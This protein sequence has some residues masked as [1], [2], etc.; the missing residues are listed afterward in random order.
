MSPEHCAGQGLD[1]RSDLYALSVIL[2]RCVTG[3]LP[4][5][6]DDLF[7]VMDRHR[8]MVPPDPRNLVD[9]PLPEALVACLA[10]GLAKHPGQR[11]A[12]AADMR[13]ALQAVTGISERPE[14]SAMATPLAAISRDSRPGT[15][16][17]FLRFADLPTP[18]GQGEAPRTRAAAPV[19]RTTAKYGAVTAD[20][21]AGLHH[22][23]PLLDQPEPE[24]T[25]ELAYAPDSRRGRGHLWPAALAIAAALLMV[26]LALFGGN[27]EPTAPASAEATAGAGP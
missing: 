9:Q 7:V 10:R 12:N 11:F 15:E 27:S 17:R 5:E 3:E 16:T 14:I 20:A 24:F 26:G 18:A 21:L 4:F 6:D 19:M 1:G 13:T 23:A 25:A 22:E 2:Y 8:S